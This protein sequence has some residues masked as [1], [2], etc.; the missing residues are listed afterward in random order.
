MNNVYDQAHKLARAIK[1]S[2]EYKTYVEKKKVLYANDNNKKMVEDFRE[3]A[4]QIQMEQISGKEVKQED[5]E[6]I[7]KLEDVLMINPSINEFLQ[8]EL[9]FSQLVQDI[10]KIIGD[11][12]NIDKD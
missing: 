3:K 9:R 11:A 7:K 1:A 8:S 10:S 12:I 4:L 5:I 2:D 6:K